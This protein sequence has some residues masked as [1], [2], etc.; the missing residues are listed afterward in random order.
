MEWLGAVA[1]VSLALVVA[2]ATAVL[3]PAVLLAL[4]TP[5][6]AVSSPYR[7][8]ASPGFRL[9]VFVT[10]LTACLIAFTY[11]P[12]THWFAWLA[13]AVPC[14]VGALV[15]ARTT[16][17]PLPL[18]RAGWLLAAV[19]ACALAI[20][21]LSWTPLP[22][23]A[24][25]ATVVGGFLWV[26]WHFTGGFGFGDVRLAAT[27]GAVTALTSLSLSFAS[28]LIGCLIGA[29]WGIV[30]RTRVGSGPFPYGPSL[31]AGPFVALPLLSLTGGLQLF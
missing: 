21:T 7:R 11:T 8:L 30:H 13:L 5:A 1:V 27:I 3:T 9:A 17:L 25:G 24:L 4:P 31:L 23:A 28:L 26:F 12:R 22:G 14:V 15:D 18:A 29:V 16:Y 20:V 10:C 19:G 6:D 2:L